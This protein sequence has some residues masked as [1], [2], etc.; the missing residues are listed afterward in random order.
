MRRGFTL[1]E[2]LLIVAIFAILSVSGLGYYRNYAKNVS[3]DS[4]RDQMIYTLKEARSRSALG[5]SG[6]G[7][8]SLRWGVHVVNGTTDYYQLYS[9]PTTYTD[10][11][12]Y[13]QSETYLNTAVT[14]SDPIEG[15][16]KDI[17]F[18]KLTGSTTPTSVSFTADGRLVTVTI[19]GLGVVY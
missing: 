13:V 18:D 6:S 11:A 10:P 5:D 14:F 19:T 17:L 7:D 8:V 15:G 4:L 9:T 16:V 3:L 12:M 2:L 1:L